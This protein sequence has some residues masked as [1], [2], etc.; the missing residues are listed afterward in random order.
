M[1]LTHFFDRGLEL[2]PDRACL[3]TDEG[4]MTYREVDRHAWRVANALR[5]RGLEKDEAVSIIAGNTAETFIA[6]LAVLRAGLRWVAVN[7]RSAQADAGAMIELTESVALLYGGGLDLDTAELGTHLQRNVVLPLE[8]QEGLWAWAAD[9]D[10]TPFPLEFDEDDI[11]I[12]I[13]TGGTTGRSK[14][15]Q[16]T[17]RNMTAMVGNFLPLMPH[18][19]DAVNLV[20]APITHGAGLMTWPQLAMGATTVLHRMVEPGRILADIERCRVTHL[21][22]PPTV[23]YAM[24]SHPMLAAHDYSSLRYFI[25]GA[26]PM[27]A[28]KLRTT[29]ETFGE[30]MVQSYG[31]VEVPCSLAL[32]GPAD[33]TEALE[34]HPHRLLSCGRAAL[35]TDLVVVDDDGNVLPDGQTGELAARGDIV[36]PGYFRNPEATAASRKNGYHLTGDVGYRDAEGFFYINDRKKDMIIS[37]GFNLFPSE[38]EQ[39]IWAIDGVQDCAVIGIPDEKWGEAVTAVIELDPGSTL[40]EDEVK[41]ACKK[42]LGSMKTPKNILFVDSLPRSSVGK[43]LKRDLRDPFWR[44]RDRMV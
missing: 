24:L 14:A 4:A 43:V 42:V 37:G 15:V 11:A 26:A 44:G 32:L 23:I 41:A 6:I 10:T 30:V 31:Q 40:S 25:Y 38:I 3:V 20:A 16:L 39:V 27:S 7:A 34:R 33:H 35:F 1:H 12:L 19:E 28:D 18:H 9:S 21:F 8:G 5:A 22:L 13:G 17:H 29:M 36:T 2:A